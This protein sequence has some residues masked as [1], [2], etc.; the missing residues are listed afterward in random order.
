MKL[1]LWAKIKESL[2]SVLPVSIIVLVTSL[3][4][5]LPLT[6]TENIIFALSSVALIIGI[7]LFNL[8]ADLAMTPMG[9]YVG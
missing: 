7:G 3:T 1:A 4:G 9:S 6:F 5:I 8:G 2:V